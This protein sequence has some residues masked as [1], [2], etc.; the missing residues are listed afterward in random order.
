[1]RARR[2]E[3]VLLGGRAMENMPA[4][5]QRQSDPENLLSFTLV[6]IVGRVGASAM[7]QETRRSSNPSVAGATIG[8]VLLAPY[9]IR[10]RA[11]RLAKYVSTACFKCGCSGRDL[12]FGGS[13]R[14]YLSTA[15]GK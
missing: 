9:C 5:L 13:S 11:G 15:R 8:L 7:V 2:R 10:E 1:M 14:Q 12:L 3:R 4:Q 6:P